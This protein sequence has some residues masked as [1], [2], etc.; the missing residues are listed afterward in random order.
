MCCLWLEQ[1]G[2][3]SAAFPS[4]G[5][6]TA[7]R[8]GSTPGRNVTTTSPNGRRS[9]MSHVEDDVTHVDEWE[10]GT[11]TLEMDFTTPLVRDAW[12]ELCGECPNAPMYA[13]LDIP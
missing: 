1:Q 7:S 10:R 13:V 3:P 4:P 11:D 6:R 12:V 9:A 2:S 8:N 5:S